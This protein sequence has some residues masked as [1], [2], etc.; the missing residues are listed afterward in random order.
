MP[1]EIQREVEL[2]GVPSDAELRGFAAAALEGSDDSS[3]CIRVVDEAEGR[4]LNHRWRGKDYATNVLAF[5][6]TAPPGLPAG[7]VPEVLG[8]VVLCAPVVAR[9]AAE[10]HKRLPDHWA[11]LVVHGVLH[12]RGFDHIKA[13]A[14]ADM[15]RREQ[16]ILATIGIEDPYADPRAGDAA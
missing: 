7:S 13:G 9:E 12:L 1:A 8:D 10:Q 3:I 4:A 15:E 5:P 11:H 2:D 16:E 6:A 14:A